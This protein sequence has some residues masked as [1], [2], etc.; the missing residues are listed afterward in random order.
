MCNVRL[1][2]NLGEATGAGF[3]NPNL[4]FDQFSII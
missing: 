1:L 4:I 2:G 3:E